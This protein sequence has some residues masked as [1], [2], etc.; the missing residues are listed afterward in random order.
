ML[1]FT[2]DESVLTLTK[3]ESGDAMSQLTFTPPGNLSS[4]N[5]FIWDGY[6]ISADDVQ[7]GEVLILTFN[8]SSTAAI[9]EYNILLEATVY[10]LELNSTE[11]KL[12]NGF[13]FVTN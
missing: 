6:E 11:F 10:D 13:I 7:D 9:G 8:V 2:Y 12:I 5:N 1:G 4:G 3:V